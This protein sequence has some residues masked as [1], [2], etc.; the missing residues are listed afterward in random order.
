[1]ID[2]ENTTPDRQ[3]SNY[4]GVVSRESPDA[5]TIVPRGTVTFAK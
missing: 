5:L 2:D 1:M 4:P 3:E